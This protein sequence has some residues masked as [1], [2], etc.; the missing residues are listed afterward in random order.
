MLPPRLNA[1]LKKIDNCGTLLDIGCDHAY[2]V[3]GAVKSGRARRGIASDIRKG[4]LLSA[5]ENIIRAGLSEKIEARL[6][7]GLSTVSPDEADIAVIAGMGGM[8]T[9]QILKEGEETARSMKKFILQ[10]MNC[11]AELRFFLCGNGYR[12]E[13]ETVVSEQRRLYTVMEVT[14]GSFAAYPK[15]IMFYTGNPFTFTDTP[16]ETLKEYFERFGEKLSR[17]IKGIERS[18]AKEGLEKY[19]RLSEE[20]LWLRSEISAM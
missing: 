14:N 7:G 8:M 1:V 13:N 2:L 11:I 12:I 5:E 16:K 9:A 20:F 15:E 4:P 10:P 18:A 17:K 19:K 3:C 6:G